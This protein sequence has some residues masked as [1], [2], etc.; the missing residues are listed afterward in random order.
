MDRGVSVPVDLNMAAQISTSLLIQK[1]RDKMKE[2]EDNVDMKPG[3]AYTVIESK[4]IPIQATCGIDAKT[5][6]VRV[7]VC[8]RKCQDIA[9]VSA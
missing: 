6:L 8:Y 4:V 1:P 2:I 3:E 9:P 7:G 5:F